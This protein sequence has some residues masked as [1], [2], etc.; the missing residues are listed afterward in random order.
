[1][2]ARLM[3]FSLALLLGWTMPAQPGLEAVG[4]TQAPDVAPGGD[5]RLLRGVLGPVTV[6]ED[7]MRG[8][9]EPVD[10]AASQLREGLSIARHRSL[11]EIPLH[12]DSSEARLIRPR[13]G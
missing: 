9:V 5:E 6:P 12:R 3:G 7:E 4:V 10:P 13:A 2:L 11:D 8:G 1:M